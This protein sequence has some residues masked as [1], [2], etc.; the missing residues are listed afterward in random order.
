MASATWVEG[1]MRTLYVAALSAL[2]AMSASAQTPTKVKVDAA[3]KTAVTT[4][5]A[6]ETL[7]PKETKAQPQKSKRFI[8]QQEAMKALAFL[9]GEWRGSSKVLRRDGWA[10]TTQSERVGV[11]LDGSVRMIEAKGYESD[12]RASFDVLRIISYEPESKTYSMRSYQS[13]LVGDHEL[14][15]TDD[16]FTL[17][18]E[19]SNNS[20]VR[21]EASVKNGVWTETA[22]RV[23]ARGEPET[24]VE[25]RMKRQRS[26]GWAATGAAGAK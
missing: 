20:T 14:S 17:Q 5:A 6:A 12:G 1:I 7:K 19:S 11:M 4:R 18:S 22:T 8:A 25:V 26:S 16:G 24:Y 23:P 13:G 3:E 15:I 21:Y 2:A 9:D 10:S